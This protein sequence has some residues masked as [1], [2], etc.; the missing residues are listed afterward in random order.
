MGQVQKKENG[1]KDFRDIKKAKLVGLDWKRKLGG[2]WCQ[3]QRWRI[4]EAEE[5]KFGRKDDEFGFLNACGGSI[6]MENSDGQF[7]IEDYI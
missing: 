7:Y 3:A 6:H 4:L 1:F 2:E 5:I